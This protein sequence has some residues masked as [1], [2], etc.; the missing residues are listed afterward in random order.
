MATSILAAITYTQQLAQTDENGIGSVL[1]LS[2]YNDSVQT[3][4]RDLLNRGIDASQTQEAYAN[5]TTDSPNTYAWPADMYALKTI[6]V[7]WQDQTEQNYLQALPV[8]VANIQNVSFSY[9]RSNQNQTQPLF[10]NRGDTFEIF[11]TPKA[12]NSQGIRIFYYLTPTDGTN[13]GQAIQYPITLDYRA[14][15]CKM[16]ALYYKTQNDAEMAAIYEKEYQERIEK[17]IKILAPGTQ[18]PITP[19]P[20]RITGWNY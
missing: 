2:L 18:Q 7:N 10:D 13:V 12:A 1:G 9:L 16:A 17:I 15:S 5:L 6:E 14:V 19:Q 4:H 20:L 8:D 11:P 3:F